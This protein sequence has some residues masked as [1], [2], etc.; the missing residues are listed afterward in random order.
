MTRKRTKKLEEEIKQFENEIHKYQN[1]LYTI[2]KSEKKDYFLWE[3]D[4]AEVFALKGGFDIVIGNPPY[5]RQE[6]IAS[7]LER[8]ENYTPDK[9]RDIKKQYKEKLIQAVQSVWKDVKK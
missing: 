7:P 3:I 4:F 5:V 6:L 9:W 1:V 8:E 2:G